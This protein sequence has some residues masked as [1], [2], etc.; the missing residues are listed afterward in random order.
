[1]PSFYG[2]F[3]S[4][5]QGTEKTDQPKPYWKVRPKEERTP[6][7]SCSSIDF[8]CFS[9]TV[10]STLNNLTGRSHGSCHQC[11]ISENSIASQLVKNG[12][13][14]A[15]DCESVRSILKEMTD[16]WRFQHQMRM[17]YLMSSPQKNSPLPF[18][19]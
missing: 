1:M 2:D 7:R 16:F 10:W 14:R 9:R 12:M 11:P 8:T 4:A 5:S 18:S 17:I 6:D 15:R 19:T 3:L 13:H